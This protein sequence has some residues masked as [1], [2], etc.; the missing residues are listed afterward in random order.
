MRGVSGWVIGS[1]EVCAY[2]L[3]ILSNVGCGQKSKT[4]AS[5]FLSSAK[6]TESIAIQARPQRYSAF[7]PPTKL[8]GLVKSSKL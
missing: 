5:K 7:V 6:D 2:K 4:I 8:E 3:V 1:P